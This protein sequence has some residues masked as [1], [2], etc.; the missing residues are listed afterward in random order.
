MPPHDLARGR[1]RS[2]GVTIREVAELSGVSTATVTRALQGHPRVLPE[3]R[4]RVEEAARALGYR[5]H[6][7]ARSLVTGASNT[8][9][10]L[11][12]STGDP[13]WGEFAVGLEQAAVEAGFSVL[14]AN[15]HGR[16]ALQ[17]RMLNLF[18]GH[19]VDG[20]VFAAAIGR[21][22][23][24]FETGEPSVPVVLVGLDSALEEDDTQRTQAMPLK[25]LVAAAARPALV[26]S[27]Y[28]QVAFDDMA[29]ARL[30]VEHLLE[31]GHCRLAHIAAPAS[32]TS[33]LRIVGFRAALDD[34]GL[35]PT[36]IVSCDQSL[37]GG[38]VAALDLLSRDE[39]PTAILTYDDLVGIGAMRAAHSVGVRVPDDLSIVGCDDIDVSAFVEPPL[40]TVRH[41]KRE[42]GRVAMQLLLSAL[43]GEGAPARIALPGTLI[44]RSSSARAPVDARAR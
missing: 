36:A 3:T 30:A 14:L 4:L 18:L 35:E 42:I 15:S 13:Y 10:L 34:A 27:R 25:A 43:G 23:E 6:S 17:S 44:V 24:W 21:P 16:P 26:G 22:D 38:R 5:P 1:R 29:G 33:L 11:I 9:G 28:A 40:T 8:I 12:P 39:R 20:I 32:R 41:P 7:L 31:L 37:E 2:R 19:R